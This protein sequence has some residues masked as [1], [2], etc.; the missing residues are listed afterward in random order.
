[1]WTDFRALPSSLKRLEKK[2]REKVNEVCT[3]FE[4]ILL[5][6]ISYSSQ[7]LYE[8]LICLKSLVIFGIIEIWGKTHTLG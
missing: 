1:M 5:W 8:I 3:K 4:S 6:G 7:T 2:L